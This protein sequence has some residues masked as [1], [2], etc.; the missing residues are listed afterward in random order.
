[1]RILLADD[2]T[3][4]RSGLRRIIEEDFPSASIDEASSCG[5][6]L[7]KMR[8]GSWGLVLLDIAMGDENSLKI[9]PQIKQ[10]HPDMPVLILSMYNDQQF[11]VQSLRA[12]A[13]GYLTKEHTPEELNHAI[14]AVLSGRRYISESVGANLAE[15]LAVGPSSAPH[16]A[17]SPR[18][19]E[20]FLLIGKGR[21]VSE[22][23]AILSV[24][25]K[26]VS[27]YRVRILEKMGLG[28]N[29]ELM[30]YAL[31]HGLVE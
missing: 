5:E 8:A 23:A 25:V 13:S 9:L 21:S 28:S 30:R 27:T 12:G 2:H 6:V 22:I 11:I 31:R 4:F 20:V 26:T 10:A 3:M 16:E 24:S 19:R 18:E 17:L 15:Y 7:E 1:M 29:A 14:R